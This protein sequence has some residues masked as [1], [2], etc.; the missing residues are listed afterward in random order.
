MNSFDFDRLVQK[1]FYGAMRFLKMSTTLNTK[2]T[3]E[4]NLADGEL[5]QVMENREEILK[6]RRITRIPK[7]SMDV[8]GNFYL[9]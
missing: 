9:L 6:L 3:T 2:F 1:L 8:T 5:L 4:T 7:V